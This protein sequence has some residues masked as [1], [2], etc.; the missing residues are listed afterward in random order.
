MAGPEG[1]CDRLIDAVD[2]LPADVMPIRL[3]AFAGILFLGALLAGSGAPPQVRERAP[4]VQTITLQQGL[5]NYQGCSGTTGS[6]GDA[7][8]PWLR[9]D[10]SPVPK[11]TRVAKAELFMCG[12]GSTHA[13]WRRKR[14][15][16][17]V[18]NFAYGSMHNTWIYAVRLTK[19]LSPGATAPRTSGE[20]PYPIPKVFGEEPLQVLKMAKS[21]VAVASAEETGTWTRWDLTEMVQWWLNNPKENFGFAYNQYTNEGNYGCG[22]DNNLQ[23]DHKGFGGPEAK[24]PSLRPKLLISCFGER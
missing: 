14:R 6:T 7:K 2:R 22:E 4:A 13:A 17:E 12:N 9:F 1:L 16:R 15:I 5:N 3:L 24:D 18:N 11:G 23:D 10:L 21:D 8:T 20:S 19:E